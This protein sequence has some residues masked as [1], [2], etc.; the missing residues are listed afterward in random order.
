MNKSKL[1]KLFSS[2]AAFNI[3][4][5]ERPVS[6]PLSEPVSLSEVGY[7]INI[8]GNFFI[9]IAP[10][11]FVISIVLSGI[12]YM[13]AGADS[14]ALARAKSWLGYSIVGGLIIFGVG[15]IINT[16]AGLIS[17]QFFCQVGI[18]ILGNSVC[19]FR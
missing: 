9:I 5:P 2:L 17:R 11:L 15:V 10:L 13:K 14:G 18:N 4:I 1:I 7:L 16:V 12:W 6:G 8:I 19:I 3:N